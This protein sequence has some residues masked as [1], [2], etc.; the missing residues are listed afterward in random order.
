[1]NISIEVIDMLIERMVEIVNR[2]TRSRNRSPHGQRRCAGG[3]MKV[4]KA[5]PATVDVAMP[6]TSDH[7]LDSFLLADHTVPFELIVG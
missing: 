5:G 3:C 2:H 7:G 4:K 1:M 6:A